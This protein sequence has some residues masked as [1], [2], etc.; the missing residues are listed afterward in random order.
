VSSPHHRRAAAGAASAGA[1]PEWTALGS[2][3]KV[4]ATTLAESL[5]LSASNGPLDFDAGPQP[6]PTLSAPMALKTVRHTG[7]QG[8][9]PGERDAAFAM[10]AID[11]QF[12]AAMDRGVD[13][14]ELNVSLAFAYGI[15]LPAA[16]RVQ[17]ETT[18]ILMPLMP[19]GTVGD[20]IR[21][22]PGRPVP[23][24]V[25]RQILRGTACGL[26]VLHRHLNAVH[27]DLT[28]ENILLASADGVT[29]ARASDGK[30]ESGNSPLLR[31]DAELCAAVADYGCASLLDAHEE[32]DA[33][34]D[35]V[36]S[37]RYMSPERLAGE[38]H[39]VRSDIWSLGVVALS[40]ALGAFP[41]LPAR[42]SSEALDGS[43]SD[44]TFWQLAEKF[45]ASQ[46]DTDLDARHVAV[47]AAV[48]EALAR[49]GCISAGWT[50]VIMRCLRADPRQRPMA[51]ELLQ[52]PFLAIS[53]KRR[54]VEP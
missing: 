19:A 24:G 29:V 34:G 36:G 3:G 33:C 12:R 5:G 53:P 14:E 8:A 25:A 30:Y 50:D 31:P 28:P 20:L 23:E 26:D 22:A 40:L 16:V 21:R 46:A 48:E 49:C 39:G 51:V 6:Q 37:V 13:I 44:D 43:A 42:G 4:Q 10:R 1:S 41:F 18:S 54:N 38:R 15:V 47:T 27:H 35:F 52:M 17:A 11:F 7:P 2:T 32:D 9:A 45:A